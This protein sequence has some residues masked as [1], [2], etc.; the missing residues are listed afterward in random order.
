MDNAKEHPETIQTA[1]PNVEVIFLPPNTT[2]LIQPVDQ[3]V[4]ATFKAFYLRRVLKSMLSEVNRTRDSG[5]LNS[6]D[7]KKLL[8]EFQHC[9]F[10]KYGWRE[11]ER[12]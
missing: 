11:L 5:N 2:S 6:E 4:I 10:I 9:P 12:S 8:E 7:G 1:H 3:S